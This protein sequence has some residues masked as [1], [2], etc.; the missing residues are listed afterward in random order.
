MTTVKGELQN[1]A[2]S[3]QRMTL[4][5]VLEQHAGFY[6]GHYHDLIKA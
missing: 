4:S 5:D 6:S 3:G 2:I 1:R